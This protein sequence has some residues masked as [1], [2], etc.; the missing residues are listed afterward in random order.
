MHSLINL[1]QRY[2]MIVCSIY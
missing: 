1:K 2:L